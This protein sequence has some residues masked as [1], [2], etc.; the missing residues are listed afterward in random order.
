M[1]IFELFKKN[2]EIEP[3]NLQELIYQLKSLKQNFRKISKELENL[4]RESKFSVQKVGVV[5]FNPFKNL[6]GNQSFSV[7]L[8]DGNND[9]IVITSFY[10]RNGNRIF[11][12]PIKKGRSH[13]ILSGEEKK[14]IETAKKTRINRKEI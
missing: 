2:E 8:L 12:K 10:N 4:K 5:R 6:G 11:G 14:A 13:H 1:S 9:G 7:A 3:K